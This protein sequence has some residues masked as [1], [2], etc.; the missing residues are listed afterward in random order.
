MG[1]EEFK[2]LVDFA[3]V[4]IRDAA[5]SCP[6]LKE[7]YL[8]LSVAGDGSTVRWNNHPDEDDKITPYIHRCYNFNEEE[9]GTWEEF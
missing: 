9:P 6:E 7:K 3:A 4:A 2:R 1:I 5:N 8:T